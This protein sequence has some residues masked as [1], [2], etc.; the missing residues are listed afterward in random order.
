MTAEINITPPHS[1]PL[2]RPALHVIWWRAIRP[3][4]LWAGA[5]PVFVG[6]GVSAH[7][8]VTWSLESALVLLC[9]LSGSLAIQIGC[10]LI[11]D[12]SDFER[13]ADDETRIGPARAA[14]QGWLTPAQLKRGAV[15]SLVSAGL[16]GVYLTAVGGWPILALGTASLIAAYAYTAGPLPLAYVGLGDLFVILFFG[17]GAVGG[18]VWLLTGVLTLDT[19]IAGGSVGALAA[20]ILVVNNLRDRHGDAASGKRT[21]AVRFGATAA[22]VEYTALV[23]GALIAL[24]GWG[25]YGVEAVDASA[26]WAWWAP[27]LVTPLA[28]MRVRQVWTHDG[29]ALNPLL[30]ATAQLELIV[31]LLLSVGLCAASLLGQG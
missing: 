23:L 7:T 21:L 29:V 24:A 1:T 5:A 10:N 11:N 14:A 9:A 16:I 31:C 6:A 13:G 17:W 3:A 8:G 27:L 18:T 12:Y 25:V 26:R 15:Y 4:T 20:A 30:G 28:L 19:F 2:E 22:R